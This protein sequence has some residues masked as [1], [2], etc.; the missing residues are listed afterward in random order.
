MTK[1]NKGQTSTAAKGNEET[2]AAAKGPW[3]L[4]K[5]NT[6]TN[7]SP[8]WQTRKFTKEEGDKRT[9]PQRNLDDFQNAIHHE[10]KHPKDAASTWD[11]NYKSLG[12][13]GP[14]GELH[15]IR[16]NQDQR[17]NFWVN[18]EN[19]T[20]KMAQIGGHTKSKKNS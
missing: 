1:H 4:A 17:A 16:L 8:L 7:Q 14:D 15:Q 12:A 3:K 9:A 11:S 18:P 5:H 10:G 6:D 20:V 2:S 19:H 13:S